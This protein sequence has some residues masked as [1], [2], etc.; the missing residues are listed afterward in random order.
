MTKAAARGGR[1]RALADEAGAAIIEFVLILPILFLL[2]AGCF[3][4]ARAILVYQAMTEAARGGARYLA[5][6]P[7]PYCRP[8]CSPGASRAV[9]M[10]RTQLLENTPLAPAS[11]RVEPLPNAPPGTV[12]MSIEVAL[13][14]DLLGVLGLD[15][16]LRLRVTHQEERVA[17]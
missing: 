4:I 2:V 5:R 6:V 8:G 7:D 13:G 15:R 3:E 14:A 11:L 9:A 10:S 1:C 12:A 17:D 16:I